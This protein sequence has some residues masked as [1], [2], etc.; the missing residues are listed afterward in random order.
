MS[1]DVTLHVMLLDFSIS[2]KDKKRKEQQTYNFNYFIKFSYIRSFWIYNNRKM[3]YSTHLDHTRNMVH[4]NYSKV[5]KTKNVTIRVCYWL[6]KY[7]T[8]PSCFFNY[9]AV[10]YFLAL[11]HD[12]RCG[13]WTNLKMQITCALLMI[14]YFYFVITCIYNYTLNYQYNV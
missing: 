4:E 13:T 12:L 5:I 2:P 3:S 6:D 9:Y 8:F 7:I 1:P 14:L 10:M 11:L